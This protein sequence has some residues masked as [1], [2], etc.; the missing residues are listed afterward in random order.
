MKDY[1]ENQIE[2]KNALITMIEAGYRVEAKKRA[3]DLTEN[4]SI[5]DMAISI[6]ELAT[7]REAYSDFISD[8]NKSL[9][10]YEDQLK[11]KDQKKLEQ[12][13]KGE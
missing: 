1:Y 6:S 3:D 7:L 8:V 13:K 4:M 12:I 9:D 10:Y 5:E 11:E 2:K